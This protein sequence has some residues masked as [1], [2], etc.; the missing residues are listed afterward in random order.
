MVHSGFCPA[1]GELI[2][3][4]RR[5]VYDF[6]KG[7]VEPDSIKLDQIIYPRQSARPPLPWE[8]PEHIREDYNEASQ[9][10]PLSPKASAALSRR[11]LQHILREHWKI[12]H[13]SLAQEIEQFLAM[14]G[15]PSYLAEAL[16]AVRAIGNLAA[17]PAK[18]QTTGLIV[19]VEPGEAEWLL[20][21][22]EL[23]CD[24]SYVQPK[25]LEQRKQQ[26]NEKLQSVGKPLV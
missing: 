22:I 3:L 10:L 12:K 26:L 14:S 13:R 24:F 6:E 4:L 16:D 15:V 11:L 23:L 7:D 20:E 1:C 18:D 25:L 19:D 5:G 2:V 17:H 9:V 21:V 8:V